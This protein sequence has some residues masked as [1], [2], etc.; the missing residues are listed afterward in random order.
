MYNNKAVYYFPEVFPAFVAVLFV[1]S[2]AAFVAVLFVLAVAAFVSV[3][4]LA[5]A[6]F[7]AV[8]FVL[9][10]AAFVA[11][12]FVLAVAAFAAVLFVFTA[13]VFSAVVFFAA[14]F[15]FTDF[16]FLAEVFLC[17]FAFFVFPEVDL[18][19]FLAVVFLA[20]SAVF[21]LVVLA[22]FAA[23]AVLAAS[24]VLTASAFVLPAAVCAAWAGTA[25]VPVM[26]MAVINRDAIDLIGF[27]IMIS[28]Y[29]YCWGFSGCDRRLLSFWFKAYYLFHT[30]FK[31]EIA[32]KLR[33]LYL[34]KKGHGKIKAADWK[35]DMI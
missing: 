17:A 22:A 7:V 35:Q 5:V 27:F 16:T 21:A 33:Q 3:F 32:A 31:G 18:A 6:A 12:L 26:S 14:A 19:D 10:V 25:K 23:S 9:A 8:L 4:V 30:H 13:V 20:V 28:P 2:V 34:L 24:V 1:F 29:F 11:V 15:F